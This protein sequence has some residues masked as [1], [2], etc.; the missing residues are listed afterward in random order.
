VNPSTQNV[1]GYMSANNA[2]QYPTGAVPPNDAR[3]SLLTGAANLGG[4]LSSGTATTVSPAWSYT[5]GPSSTSQ[6]VDGV[7]TVRKISNSGKLG[8]D[9][10]DGGFVIE[11]PDISTTGNFGAPL[12]LG[13][14]SSTQTYR[15]LVY[16]SATGYE[17]H[18]QHSTDGLIT[19]Y[20]DIFVVT[21]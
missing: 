21:L 9:I 14:P 7:M 6:V 20:V 17:W 4:V 18:L 2:T 10:T 16:N 11:N 5:V 19:N 3:L 8:Y 1:L 12:Y 13:I 15:Q